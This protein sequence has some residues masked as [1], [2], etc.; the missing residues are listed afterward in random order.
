[1][2]C[3]RHKWRPWLAFGCGD[4]GVIDLCWQTVQVPGP[5]NALDPE[6]AVLVQVQRVHVQE[7]A[8]V[9]AGEVGEQAAG[10]ELLVSVHCD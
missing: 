4:A 3:R 1:M 5:A 8:G 6:H 7:E 2:V 10:H 9:G